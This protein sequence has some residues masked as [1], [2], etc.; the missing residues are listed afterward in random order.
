MQSACMRFKDEDIGLQNIF[1]AKLRSGPRRPVSDG[2][3]TGNT[4]S[5]K[6]RNINFS[7]EQLI[8]VVISHSVLALKRLVEGSYDTYNTW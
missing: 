8:F 1:A 6:N 2:K 5:A 4:S 7:S 3:A